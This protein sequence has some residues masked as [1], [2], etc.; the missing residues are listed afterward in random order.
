MDPDR[1]I[2]GT[3]D[4]FENNDLQSFAT[5]LT[6]PSGTLAATAT[7]NDWYRI[8][9][10][11]GLFQVDLSS[12]PS[13]GELNIEIYTGGGA[14][15][16]GNYGVETLSTLQLD[17]AEESELLI[18]VYAIGE[19]QGNVYDL[20]WSS[21]GVVDSEG[22]VDPEDPDAPQD[23]ADPVDPADPAGP[24]DSDVAP[25]LEPVLH[26]AIAQWAQAATTGRADIFVLG[27]SV[28]FNNGTGWDGGLNAGFDRTL[29]L[30]GTGLLSGNYA[31]GTDAGYGYE[32]FGQNA[33]NWLFDFIPGTDVPSITNDEIFSDQF[34]RVQHPWGQ[35]T[36]NPLRGSV[37]QL[38]VNLSGNGDTAESD[39]AFTFQT[40]VSGDGATFNV[41]RTAEDGSV[42]VVGLQ[43]VDGDGTQLFTFDFPAGESPAD[44]AAS[45]AITD[46]SQLT[47]VPFDS[48]RSLNEPALTVSNF[49]LLE[50]GSTGATVTSW[51]YGGESTREFFA[52]Q[53]EP[54]GQDNRAEL[55]DR[56]VDGGSGKLLVFIMEG[57]NDRSEDLPSLNGIADGDST[58]AFIDN[59]S[60]LIDGVRGDWAAAGNDASDL[61]F[62]T[63]GTYDQG[64]NPE[65][66]EYSAALQQQA[67]ETEDVSFID[68]R[69]LSG[70]LSLD[71]MVELGYIQGVDPTGGGD[72]DFIH[73]T[74][75]GSVFYGEAIATLIASQADAAS[76][77]DVP[78]DNGLGG[79][80]LGAEINATSNAVVFDSVSQTENAELVF[81][82]P[83][84]EGVTPDA[85]E[86]SLTWADDTTS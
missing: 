1:P 65:L 64:S 86:F 76:P 78:V 7:E 11:A 17:L 35:V 15:I 28:V 45:I 42:D 12:I 54:V 43:E 10:G 24:I 14:Y 29:G 34:A 59:V 74:E 50:T 6:A 25:V 21:E 13:E 80:D 60:T 51:G 47:F 79:I 63:F 16:T 57:L 69:T 62:V 82:L 70:G 84:A 33:S 49:R 39:S 71:Q 73:L 67:T 46:P 9:V 38:G 83:S 52:E 3:L 40:W 31:A 18:L 23:P 36:V 4:Q 68:L 27:D 22:P 8:Q 66:E 72:D 37:A 61:H 32:A 41:T 44:A 77:A 26:P 5:V 53:Y 2:A 81:A 85:V 75:S 19:Y 20:S 58:E 48:G 30:A 55:L 56:I